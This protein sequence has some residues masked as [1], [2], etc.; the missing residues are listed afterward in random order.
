MMEE[1]NRVLSLAAGLKLR[2]LQNT[3]GQHTKALYYQ[4]KSIVP[5]VQ[6]LYD[7]AEIWNPEKGKIL[8]HMS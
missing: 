2:K 8:K 5:V 7:K 3:S 4:G 1:I 6:W